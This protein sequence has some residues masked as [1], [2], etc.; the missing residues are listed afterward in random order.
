VKMTGGDPSQVRVKEPSPLL[1]TGNV[2]GVRE[3]RVD[4]LE[5]H[6]AGAGGRAGFVSSLRC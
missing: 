1:A 6:E 2:N 3:M 5:M 4:G